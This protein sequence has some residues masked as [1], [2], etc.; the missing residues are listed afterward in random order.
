MTRA[1]QKLILVADLKNLP[2]TI[3]KWQDQVN[4]HG[5]ITLNNKLNAT[6]PMSFIGPAIDWQK[7]LSQKITDINLAAETSQKLLYLQYQGENINLK[8]QAVPEKAEKD[9][10]SALTEYAKKLYNFSYP[11]QDASHTTAYQ[12]VSEIKKLLMT[13]L[14]LNLKT[15]T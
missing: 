6:N 5:Q 10:V 15:R 3:E 8:E 9:N 2:K 12:S 14:M 4:Q 13:L 7:L 11:F 1:K